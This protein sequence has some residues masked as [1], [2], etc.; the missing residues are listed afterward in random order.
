ME[1]LCV[2]CEQCR[3]KGNFKLLQVNLLASYINIVLV[4][5]TQFVRCA[6]QFQARIAIL[7]IEHLG[8]VDTLVVVI[9]DSWIY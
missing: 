3:W 8:I 7:Y 4:S 6:M 9:F 2:Y 5:Q 1:G